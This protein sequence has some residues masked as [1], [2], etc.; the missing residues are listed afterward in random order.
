MSDEKAYLDLVRHIVENGDVREG[1]NGVTRS[2][3]NQHLAFDLK[4]GQLPLLTTRTIPLKIIFEELMF[5]LRGQTDVRILQSKGVR[6]WDA[7][8][9]REALDARGLPDVPEF[10]MYRGYGHQWRRFGGDS[11]KGD[12]ILRVLNSLMT[13][14]YSRRIVLTSWNP[15]D[16]D[17]MAL[18]PCHVMYQ[19][20]VDSQKRV[21]CVLTMR[22]SDVILGLPFNIVSASLMTMFLC[23][24]AGL[25]PTRLEVNMHDSH[26]YENQIG[27]GLW[28]QL[29][30]HPYDPPVLIVQKRLESLD[31][32][33]ALEM[34]D[35][36]LYSYNHHPTIK[37]VMSV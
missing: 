35:L 32:I 31:D 37:Y 20:L 23:K 28:L 25:E 34:G 1:R 3:F 7:N 30:R 15:C 14:P 16:V 9:T 22:S 6:I 5:F 26:V 19:W 29:S 4:G 8:T 18:P 33:L 2:L 21:T 24:V 12:Q 13:D 17:H 11:F 10:E 27:E 36:V